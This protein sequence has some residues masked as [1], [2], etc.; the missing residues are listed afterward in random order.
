MQAALRLRHVR[1]LVRQQRLAERRLRIRARAFAHEDHA[2]VGHGDGVGAVRLGDR[3]GERAAEHAHVAEA[4][5]EAPLHLRLRAEVEPLARAG[6]ADHELGQPRRAPSACAI[7]WLRL[8]RALAC[9]PLRVSSRR[10]QACRR[11]PS[12]WALPSVY[13]N[14]RLSAKARES[15][16]P[17]A[18]KHAT[19]RGE[20]A[21]IPV[22]PRTRT[23]RSSRTRTARHPRPSSRPRSSATPTRRS[24]PSRPSTTTPARCSTS[25]ASRWRTA[26]SALHGPGSSRRTTRKH[27]TIGGST[28]RSATPSCSR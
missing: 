4:A 6:A 20:T 5:A 25:S 27:S 21:I 14:H 2:G 28:R 23:R 17:A 24:S 13:S 22:W 18:Q 26:L 9:A 3:L 16:V 7:S 19:F 11:R 12:P 15:C 8:Q 10:R 1:E